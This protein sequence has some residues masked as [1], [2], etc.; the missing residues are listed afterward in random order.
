MSSFWAN[1]G[2]LIGVLGVI[3]AGISIVWRPLSRGVSANTLRTTLD[4]VYKALEIERGERKKEND[5]CSRRL[6]EIDVVHQREIG[7][8]QGQ[9]NTL[10]G[11]FVDAL[12]PQLMQRL[13]DDASRK[14]FIEG[15]GQELR[16]Q[17]AT[18]P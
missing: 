11:Q 2:I 4:D 9:I 6:H 16:K 3:V 10:T 14:E 8:L 12:A 1:A 13:H 5:E 7:H 15:I 18:M 17:G